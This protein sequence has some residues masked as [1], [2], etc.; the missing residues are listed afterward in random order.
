MTLRNSYLTSI[1]CGLIEKKSV[2]DIHKELY[3]NTMKWKAKGLPLDN[4]MYDNAK[5][6]TSKLKKKVPDEIA[7]IPI[8]AGGIFELFEKHD[9]DKF[10]TQ[11]IYKKT[12][13]EDG[14]QKKK[15]IVD[16]IRNNRLMTQPKV[17][18]LASTHGDSASDHVDYQ[19]KVYID[20]KWKNYIKDEDIRNQIS[21][22]IK[23]HNVKTLQ[24]VIG[25]PVWFVTRPNCRH[26]FKN[27]NTYDVLN[28]SLKVLIED[29][30]VKSEIGERQY[31][32]TKKHPT[33]KKWYEDKRNAE[34]ILK[35]YEE[36]LEYHKKLY[37][38]YPS[39][40]LFNAIKKDQL[41]IK[42]WK[43]YLKSLNK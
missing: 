26:Y 42:K 15:V 38:E 2:K 6:L 9:A 20:E 11:N 29:Y 28:Q 36:R 33:N 21:T 16:E 4:V 34:Q 27:M 5:K 18:Y 12:A 14:K 43:D 39:E 35:K 24:W 22:Y 31:L 37:N 7:S 17:F 3:E 32:Q 41:L 25:K 40:Q 1:Y 8:L 19:G 23:E 13:K 30:N 10:L